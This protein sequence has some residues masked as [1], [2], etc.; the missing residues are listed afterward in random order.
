MSS[1]S[2]R[3][4]TGQA[5]SF[6]P[7]VVPRSAGGPDGGGGTTPVVGRAKSAEPTTSRRSV[8]T[9]AAGPVGVGAHDVRG[10]DAPRPRRLPC[11]LQPARRHLHPRLEPAPLRPR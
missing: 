11:P 6:T 8:H 5:L 2:K 1:P 9:A 4:S 10:G 3:P 7:R